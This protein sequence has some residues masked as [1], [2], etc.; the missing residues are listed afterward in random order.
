MSTRAA[1]PL[2]GLF[3]AA[4]AL[5]ALVDAARALS[6]SWDLEDPACWSRGTAGTAMTFEG[7][8]DP[9]S[10]RGVEEASDLSLLDDPLFL[11]GVAAEAGGALDDVF[12]LLTTSAYLGAPFPYLP[13][14]SR[15]VTDCGVVGVRESGGV[16]VKERVGRAGEVEGSG[17]RG[18]W[19]GKVSAS[20]AS[21]SYTLLA[22]A[23]LISDFFIL[24]GSGVKSSGVSGKL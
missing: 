20:C 17:E 8:A 12:F 1:D 14:I 18:G 23:A 7:A 19:I 16:E 11:L 10:A 13:M 15:G 22:L 6:L 24:F 9:L 5:R 3:D 4:D 2:R 21:P